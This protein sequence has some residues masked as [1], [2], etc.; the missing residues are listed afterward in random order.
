MSEKKRRWFQI[1]L[2]TAIVL[3]FLASGILFKNLTVIETQ[4]ATSGHGDPLGGGTLTI[5]SSGWPFI[6]TENLSHT[7]EP[8]DPEYA[9]SFDWRCVALN[10]LTCISSLFAV[11]LILEWRIRR[12]E[13]RKP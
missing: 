13:A 7:P 9:H 10:V 12:R 5:K 1:H 11:A 6:I 8:Y 3:M 2:S 4:Y